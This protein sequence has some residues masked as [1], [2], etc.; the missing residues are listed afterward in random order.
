MSYLSGFIPIFGPYIYWNLAHKWL[1]P[2][3]ISLGLQYNLGTQIVIFIGIIPSIISNL[4]LM[5][6]LLTY[7]LH[8]A[9]YRK[10]CRKHI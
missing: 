4:F 9:D 6:F 3:F 1:C 10:P 5:L 7:A 2:L 8:L